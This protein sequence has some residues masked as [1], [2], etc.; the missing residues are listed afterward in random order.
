MLRLLDKEEFVHLFR[1]RICRDFPASERRP[2]FMIS[3]PMRRG[4]YLTYVLDGAAAPDAYATVIDVGGRFIHLEC[5]A[6]AESLRGHGTG[7]RF[8]PMLREEHAGRTII[9]ECESPQAAADEA[10]RELRCRRIAFYERLGARR[11]Q[12]G[13]KLLGHDFALL[14]FPAD[15]AQY[16]EDDAVSALEQAYRRTLPPGVG[17]LAAHR[18]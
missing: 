1:D 2:M 13:W 12:T 9:L 6:V 11:L 17:R 4:E 3:E 14:V 15:G 16:T 7:S 18:A 5:F 10:E 8:I